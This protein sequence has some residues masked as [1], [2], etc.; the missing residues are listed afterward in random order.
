MLKAQGILDRIGTDHL[1]GNV[2]RAVEAHLS[3]SADDE[4]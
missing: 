1:H 3:Q 2:H 4:T